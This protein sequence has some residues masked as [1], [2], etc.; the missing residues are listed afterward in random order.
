MPLERR[1]YLFRYA[2]PLDDSVD[3]FFVSSSWNRFM[4]NRPSMHGDYEAGDTPVPPIFGEQEV[5]SFDKVSVLVVSGFCFSLI[6][7]FS[8]CV[9]LL[10]APPC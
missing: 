2:R 3:A 9:F 4:I 8:D 7:F 10:D 1:A 6:L 5:S